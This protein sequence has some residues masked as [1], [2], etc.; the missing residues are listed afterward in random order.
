[1][2]QN[3]TFAFNWPDSTPHLLYLATFLQVRPAGEFPLHDEHTWRTLLAEPPQKALD[4]FRVHG[5]VA[6]AN[7]YERLAYQCTV[8]ELRALLHARQLHT[9]GQKDELIRRLTSAAGEELITTLPD[10]DLVR[11][12]ES[13]RRIAEHFLSDPETIV[14]LSDKKFSKVAIT[15]L[16]Y[17]LNASLL[18]PVIAGPAYALL[19]SLAGQ[20][21]ADISQVKKPGRFLD[22]T[23]LAPGINI[24]WCYVPGGAFRMGSEDTDA[25]AFDDEKPR[26]YLYLDAFYM[27]KFPVTN[28]QY[29]VFIQATGYASPP[30]WENKSYPA[31]AGDHPVHRL[32]WPDAVAF[33]RWAAQHTG[34][35]LRLPT[36]AEWEKACRGS[37]GRLWPWGNNWQPE[38]ANV[39]NRFGKTTP[40]DSFPRGASPYGVQDMIGNVWEWTGSVYKPY[41]Y[42][43]T[44]GR[45]R[46]QDDDLHVVRGGSWYSNDRLARATTRNHLHG[47]SYLNG[48]RMALTALFGG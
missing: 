46:L 2:G 26:H 18:S 25:L 4:R 5:S 37:D 34:L 38:W 7:L 6:S 14:R 42:I 3:F 28:H 35:P 40:V 36:E 16:T 41:P 47:P 9:D 29:Q 17:L 43:A 11:C 31:G 22:S 27:A 20:S 30:G 24:A 23:S 33:C 44:D 15:L 48:F 8:A 45:E 13:G 32:Y 12:T 19:Q 10:V 1:M 39:E 21:G